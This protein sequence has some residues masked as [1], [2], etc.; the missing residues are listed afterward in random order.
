MELSQLIEK[1]IG[2]QGVIPA[3]R[4][5]YRKAGSYPGS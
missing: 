5:E 2:R 4:E 3:H 1:N